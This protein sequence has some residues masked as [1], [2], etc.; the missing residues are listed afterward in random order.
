VDSAYTY[1][2]DSTEYIDSGIDHL[3]GETVA[4]FAD[5]EVFDDAVVNANVILTKEIIGYYSGVCCSSRP[6]VHNES[7]VDE[8]R[9][10]A[11]SGR[12]AD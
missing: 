10:S 4:V 7:K 8:T 11:D 6:S 9:R 2:G 5:G 3:V 12:L 1:D